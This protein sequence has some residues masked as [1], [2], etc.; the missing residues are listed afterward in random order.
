MNHDRY[1]AMFLLNEHFLDEQ[2]PPREEL[3]SPTNLG[4]HTPTEQD[5]SNTLSTPSLHAQDM[6]Q[7]SDQLNSEFENPSILQ[8]PAITSIPRVK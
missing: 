8:S 3:S 5:A 4:Y 1:G 7:I 2:I 6:L